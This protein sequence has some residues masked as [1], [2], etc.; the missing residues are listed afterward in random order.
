MGVCGRARPHARGLHEIVAR[1]SFNEGYDFQDVTKEERNEAKDA[2]F[3]FFLWVF[4]IFLL[5]ET[6][7]KSFPLFITPKLP[8]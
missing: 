7:E 3:F 6:K 5:Q 4:S 8:L 2:A 1:E